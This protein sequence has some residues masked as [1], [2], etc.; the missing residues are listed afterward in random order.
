[1]ELL[2][3]YVHVLPSVGMKGK[4]MLRVLVDTYN[5]MYNT[6]IFGFLLCTE[7]ARDLATL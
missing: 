7:W 3:Q 6:T 4:G 2:A 5:I 1:M